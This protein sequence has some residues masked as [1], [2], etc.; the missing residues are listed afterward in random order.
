MHYVVDTIKSDTF[1][2]S[3][4][5]LFNVYD[6]N[7]LDQKELFNDSTWQICKT[8]AVAQCE[9]MFCDFI[10][11]YIFGESYLYAFQYLLS[12]GGEFRTPAYPSVKDRADA[13]LKAS[14]DLSFDAPKDFIREFYEPDLSSDPVQQ[15]LLKIA[16]KAAENSIPYLKESAR[17]W[18]NDRDIIKHDLEDINSICESFKNL[19]PAT[20]AKSLSN[21]INAAWKMKI[22]LDEDNHWEKD[23]PIT[24]ELSN[25]KSELLRELAL[26]SFEVFEIER[27]QEE[28]NA[29]LSK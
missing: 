10:G 15:L 13:L 27:I 9:E 20:G 29:S 26:K 22:S 25:K 21:I 4:S 5:K 11:L 3:F 19:V 23:Y 17:N 24:S 2:D 28:R 8:W 12:P 16:D 6:K 1:W 14:Q 7:L 18:C